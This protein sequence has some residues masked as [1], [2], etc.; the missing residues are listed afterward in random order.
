MSSN[1]LRL[2]L[3][4]DA[5]PNHVLLLCQVVA[6]GSHLHLK[7]MLLRYHQQTHQPRP[8]GCLI[9]IRTQKKD[10]TCPQSIPKLSKSSFPACKTTTSTLCLRTSLPR[11]PAAIPRAL[12][13]G[14]RGC[15][16]LG[17]LEHVSG[18]TRPRAPTLVASLL[19]RSPPWVHQALPSLHNHTKES[20]FNPQYHSNPSKIRKAPA[21]GWS[22]RLGSSHVLSRGSWEP[23][24]GSSS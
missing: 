19:L 21:V 13:C 2:Q 12:V 11:T 8:S 4:N 17:R 20:S 15:S 23:D 1:S 24:R 6:T 22:W 18:Q 10:T 3:A 5:S 7:P 9:S 16:N 14:A